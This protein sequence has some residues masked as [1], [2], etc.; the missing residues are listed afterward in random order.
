MYLR[1][2]QAGALMF[3]ILGT[4]APVAAAVLMW[5]DHRSLAWVSFGVF[6]VILL[7]GE[8]T[9]LLG[10][11]GIVLGFGLLGYAVTEDRASGAVA[12]IVAGT[13][14]YLIAWQVH[15]AKRVAA[16]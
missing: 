2:A 5:S 11:I 10:V 14:Y 7:F 6:A 8:K 1:L 4:L 15:R 13:I 3:N 16:K 9:P 12:A